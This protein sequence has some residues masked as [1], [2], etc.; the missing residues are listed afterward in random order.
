MKTENT[1]IGVYLI[2]VFID[3]RAGTEYPAL[4]NFK[5]EKR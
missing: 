4:F 2:N 5:K 3:K 1:E